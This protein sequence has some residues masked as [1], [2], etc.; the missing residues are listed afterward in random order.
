MLMISRNIVQK[1]KFSSM[2]ETPTQLF[3]NTEC[4]RTPFLIEQIRWLLLFIW[5][6]FWSKAKSPIKTKFFKT[7]PRTISTVNAC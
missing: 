7:I 5:K 2:K 3:S 4:L 6:N 1:F